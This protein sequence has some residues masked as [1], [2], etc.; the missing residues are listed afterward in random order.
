VASIVPEPHPADPRPGDL[1]LR[2][3]A[4]APAERGRGLGAALVAACLAFARE[5]GAPRVWLNARTPAVGLYARAGFA[6]ETGVVEVP[7][8][9]P[10]VRMSRVP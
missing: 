8:I 9:G 5:E 2:G 10:H 1:R 7:G 3:M 4:T 6:R